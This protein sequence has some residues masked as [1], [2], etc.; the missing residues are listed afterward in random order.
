MYKELIILLLNNYCGF[1]SNSTVKEVCVFID[2]KNMHVI[3]RETHT[4][5]HYNHIITTM[6][7]WKYM[8]CNSE[9]YNKCSLT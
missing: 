3:I 4:C 2:H 6:D 1:T 7:I 5:T 9:S 8:Y